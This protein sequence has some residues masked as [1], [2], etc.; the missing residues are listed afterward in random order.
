[1]KPKIPALRILALSKGQP[2]VLPPQAV[3]PPDLAPGEI[4][5]IPDTQGKDHWFIYCDKQRWW[6][7]GKW[8]MTGTLV[9]FDPTKMTE[10]EIYAYRHALLQQCGWIN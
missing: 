3:L 5:M 4:L 8:H 6:G 7:N 1:M 2:P 10:D 9:E